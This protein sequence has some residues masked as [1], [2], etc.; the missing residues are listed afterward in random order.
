MELSTAFNIA[1]FTTSAVLGYLIRVV[2]GRL[3]KLEEADQK[4]AKSLTDLS[5]EL[6]KN[7]TSKE[8]FKGMGDSL[9]GAIRNLGVDMRAGFQRID[10]KLDGKAD[11]T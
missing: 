4:L 8:D 7:Y 9:F 5:I 1:L 10:D 11:R 2:L 3:D 6:P